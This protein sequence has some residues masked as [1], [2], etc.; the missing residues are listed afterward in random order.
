M[1]NAI[2]AGVT[3]AVA[4]GNSNM[5]ACTTSPARTPGAL[6]VGATTSADARASF[7]NYGSC[8]D[9]FA[10]GVSITSAYNSSDTA[11]ATMSG[12]SMASPHVAGVAALYLQAH[13]TASPAT[14]NN[15]VVTSASANVVTG[16][17][18]G[19][20]NRLLYS[21]F[22]AVPAP[23]PTPTP[24]PT[25]VPSTCT[26]LPLTYSGSLS[27]TGA[28]QY[29]P[30]GS[31]YYSSLSGTHR[32]CLTGPA[33]ADFDL[34]L[35]KWNGSSWAVVA[36]GIGTTAS[37]DVSYSGTPGYYRWRIYSYRGLGAYT[38]KMKKP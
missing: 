36:R 29:Q 15:A 31:Y 37:E 26:T 34:Y 9:V 12:T 4:A 38:L 5:D 18:T 2:N 32:A 17:G 7:S 23:T 6:T 22:S 3:F 19:S 27:G 1:T 21:L 30:N 16:A 20:P 33:T 28:S 8:V 25:P 13:P 10:P 14:V 11:T 35:Q 24:T